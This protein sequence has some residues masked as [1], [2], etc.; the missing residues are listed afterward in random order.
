MVLLVTLSQGA[1]A[2]SYKT[3]HTHTH[4]PHTVDPHTPTTYTHTHTQHKHREKHKALVHAWAI[5]FSIDNSFF[6][7]YK[8]Q[9]NQSDNIMK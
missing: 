3:G 1:K 6:S 5:F 9:D 8:L 7:N 2:G 4:K